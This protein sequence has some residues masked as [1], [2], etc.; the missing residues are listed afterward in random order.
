[1][2][3]APLKPSRVNGSGPADAKRHPSGPARAHD[4]KRVLVAPSRRR[5]SQQRAR[6]HDPLLVFNMSIFNSANA[7]ECIFNSLLHRENV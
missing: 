6:R 3:A 7:R 2:I 5:R 4:R 1:M